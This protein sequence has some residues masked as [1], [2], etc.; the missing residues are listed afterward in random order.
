[1]IC[2]NVSHIGCSTAIWRGA[3]SNHFSR[4]RN[5]RQKKP[6]FQ[7]APR[8]IAVSIDSLHMFVACAY[9][10]L[11]KEKISDKHQKKRI[12]IEAPHTAT[13]NG[14]QKK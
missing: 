8:H 13:Q 11:Q 1:M 10:D 9:C 6:K 5:I 3:S 7:E 12:T 14:D 2:A 4:M